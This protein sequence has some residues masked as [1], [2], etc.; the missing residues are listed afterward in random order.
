MKKLIPE[1]VFCRASIILITVVSLL[2]NIG[3]CG[4]RKSCQTT[5]KK[6]P[7]PCECTFKERVFALPSREWTVYEKDGGGGPPVLLLHELPGLNGGALTLANELAASRLKCRVY[8]PLLFGKFGQDAA[9]WEGFLFLFRGIGPRW[10]VNSAHS[11]GTI[12]QEAAELSEAIQRENQG[13]PLI[14]IGNC[15]TGPWPVALLAEDSVAGGI[16]CQPTAPML[17][18]TKALK[19]NL[20]IAP[21][22]L[23]EIAAVAKKK[24]KALLGFRY[25][26]DKAA[27][28]AIAKRFDLLHGVFGD[29][30]EAHVLAKR[31]DENRVIAPS[32]WLKA[33]HS[34]SHSTLI[35]NAAQAHSTE[36]AELL[37]LTLD[38]ISQQAGWRQQAE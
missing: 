12:I 31:E 9:L 5:G 36:R 17:A 38:M 2:S 20:G 6:R 37:R 15:L 29:R 1:G 8:S 26:Q 4:L 34:C 24:H 28:A 25:L 13:R 32:K 11:L 19:K 22:R 7:A 35:V 33:D 18:F 14:V 21:M 3:C 16:V 10:G 27:G 23:A 30:F